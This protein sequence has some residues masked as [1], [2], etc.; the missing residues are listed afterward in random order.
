[1]LNT[2]AFFNM[3][4][5]SWGTKGLTKTKDPKNEALQN[6]LNSFGR[7]FVAA[8]LVTNAL[9]V[10]LAGY[11]DVTQS[12]LSAFGLLIV[13]YIGLGGIGLIYLKIKNRMQPVNHTQRFDVILPKH[14]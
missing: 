5:S 14:S 1:M 13:S 9:A 10:A 2:Y 11:F 8:W 12:V 6:R 3:N 4:D 7:K